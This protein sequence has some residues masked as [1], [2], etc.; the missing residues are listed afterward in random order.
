[1][2]VD[3]C[4]VISLKDELSFRAESTTPVGSRSQARGGA[5]PARG[6]AT[7]APQ[8]V[9]QQEIY[10]RSGCLLISWLH[11]GDHGER[12]LSAQVNQLPAPGLQV[13]PVRMGDGTLLV[14][15]K[16]QDKAIAPQEPPVLSAIMMNMNTG[17][18]PTGNSTGQ[19]PIF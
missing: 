1:M 12:G 4:G 5:G 16:T 8:P 14:T 3:L 15:Q 19:F 11:V 7:L 10:H 9:S 6:L 17:P 2:S 13:F 18:L